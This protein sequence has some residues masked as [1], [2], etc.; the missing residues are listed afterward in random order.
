MIP[1]DIEDFEPI[2]VREPSKKDAE[3]CDK[4]GNDKE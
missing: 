1:C 2:D 3:N 4:Y